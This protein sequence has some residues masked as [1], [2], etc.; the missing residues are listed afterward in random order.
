MGTSVSLPICF[1]GLECF[2]GIGL[3][4][5]DSHEQGYAVQ[6]L[7]RFVVTHHLITSNLLK[8]HGTVVFVANSGQTLQDLSVE[9]LSLKQ[10]YAAGRGK[11][12]FFMDQSLRDSSVLDS[13]TIVSTPW[14]LPYQSFEPKRD[15]RLT[16]SRSSTSVIPSINSTTCRRVSLDPR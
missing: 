11:I 6:S 5:W 1:R 4:L 13:I 16:M 2:S 3:M 14:M 7:S 8:D 10:R 9:D 12:G 15:D